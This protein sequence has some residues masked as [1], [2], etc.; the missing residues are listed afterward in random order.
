MVLRFHALNT[1]KPFCRVIVKGTE[2]FDGKTS[3]YVDY[4]LTDVL[5]M[6]GRAGRPG[7][8]TSAVAIVMCT[9]EMKT[10]YQKVG[11]VQCKGWRASSDPYLP[12]VSSFFLSC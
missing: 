2:F 7:F 5:Q 3:R 6:V 9:E 1:C 4:P 12:K 8:D 10:F 11:P